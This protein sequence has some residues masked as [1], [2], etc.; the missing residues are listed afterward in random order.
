[1][2]ARVLVLILYIAACVGVELV[3]KAKGDTVDAEWG[4]IVALY[5]PNLTT[6]MLTLTQFV[7]LDSIGEIYAPLVKKQPLLMVYFAIF[8]LVV[9][10]TLMNLITATI[11]ESSLEQSSLDKDVAKV[12]TTASDDVVGCS[13]CNFGRFR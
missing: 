13:W 9:S 7:T 5:F 3:T 2:G 4:D 8:L 11:V 6:T 12:R 10:I 1:M